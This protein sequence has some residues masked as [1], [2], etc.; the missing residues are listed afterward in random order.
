MHPSAVHRRSIHPC[1]VLLVLVL[2][3]S[4]S[5]SLTARPP[6]DRAWDKPFS[7]S[8]ESK[9][10]ISSKKKRD[11]TWS[12]SRRG[13]ETGMLGQSLGHHLTPPWKWTGNM[14][15]EFGPVSSEDQAV[16]GVIHDDYC[17]HFGECISSNRSF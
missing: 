13:F 9:Y 15:P 16:L 4:S 17:R 1:R 11:A 10:F 6:A 12:A 14:V 8:G 7:E 3:A 5:R 2:H